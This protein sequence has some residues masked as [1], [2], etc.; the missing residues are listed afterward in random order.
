M[1]GVQTCALPISA[2]RPRAAAELLLDGLRLC[3][4]F[5]RGGTSLI[6]T[7]LATAAAEDLQRMLEQLLNHKAPLGAELAAQL[8]SELGTLVASQPHPATTLAGE[9][10]SM[11]LYALLPGANPEDWQPPGGWGKGADP[12]S[13]RPPLRSIQ[14]VHPTDAVVLGWLAMRGLWREVL[15]GCTPADP[16]VACYERLR[17]VGRAKAAAGLDELDAVRTALEVAFSPERKRALRRKIIQILQGV[18][19]PA[20][21]RYVARQGAGLFSLQA[22]RLAAAYRQ[23]AEAAGR[24]PDAAVFAAPALAALR[25]DPYSGRPIRVETL[26]PARFALRPTVPIAEQA[27]LDKPLAV[28]IDCPFAAP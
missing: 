1:T 13:F 22:L 3:Q 23:R 28:F 10:R 14:A 19:A 7:M 5:H 20:F 18:A 26:A 4:D 8:E 16:P 15:A 12:A 11:A 17:R 2:G 9:M 27:G 6:E 24:C 25:R 21:D